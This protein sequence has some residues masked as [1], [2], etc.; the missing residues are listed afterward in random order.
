MESG[1]QENFNNA[2]MSAHLGFLAQHVLVIDRIW[3]HLAL[4]RPGDHLL[5]SIARTVALIGDS[6][7]RYTI[8]VRTTNQHI[9]MAKSKFK[10]APTLN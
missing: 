3:P 8:R 5:E 9:Y 10:Y 2:V 7:L 1:K 6:A 4:L